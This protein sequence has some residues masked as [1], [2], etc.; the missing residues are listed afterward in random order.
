MNQ[1]DKELLEQLASFKVNKNRFDFFLF[2]Y[3][4]ILVLAQFIV[5][6]LT[7]IVAGIYLSLP[8]NPQ[9]VI[10]WAVYSPVYFGVLLT[11]AIMAVTVRNFLNKI[12][13]TL[14][15]I[16]TDGILEKEDGG[17]IISESYRIFLKRFEQKLNS[18]Q[19]LY[20]GVPMAMLGLFF[21]WNT[22]HIPYMFDVWFN[23]T[24]WALKLVVT[25]VNFFA[26]FLPAI[27]V[28]YAIGIGIWKSVI[29]A[30]NIRQLCGE[31]KLKI[32]SSHPDK[33][34]GLKPLGS[35]ILSLA[36]TTIVASLVL[37]GMIIFAGYFSYTFVVLYSKIFLA[38]SIALSVIIFIWPLISAHERMLAE[39]RSLEKLSLE[40]TERIFELEES[41]QK[42]IRK[43]DYKTRQEVF[44]E[45]DSLKDLYRRL[46]NVPTWPFDREI[47]LKFAT[48]QIFS[49]LSLIGVAEPIV[50]A[51]R[52]LFLVMTGNQP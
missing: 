15:Q 21:F 10:T 5:T 51:V 39:K 25:F 4:P 47:I 49:V 33:A 19:R 18:L 32:Q 46:G 26:L 1:V 12:P 48:P 36:S 31:F 44:N 27:V 22:G 13:Q 28:G 34:G 17:E 8:E 20:I 2:N 14:T 29:T 38:I 16:W 37:S 3:S 42:N 23:G 40:I 7:V 43:M 50:G 30:I 6:I 52:S 11:L 35:L 45:I 41:T 9:A 24:D